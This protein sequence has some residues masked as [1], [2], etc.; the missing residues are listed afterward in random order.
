MSRHYLSVAVWQ[1]CLDLVSQQGTIQL[2]GKEEPA[3]ILARFIY[4]YQKRD[5]AVEIN[6]V[7]FLQ[8]SKRLLRG[9]RGDV[10]IQLCHI[11]SLIELSREPPTFCRSGNIQFH[12]I[13]LRLQQ[14]SSSEAKVTLRLLLV[15]VPLI[16]LQF[17]K[18]F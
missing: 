1:A 10:G 18:C 16:V 6:Q 8:G 14:L 5:L 9:C 4:Y 13:F 12:F 17:H 2:A 3:Q 7:S 11:F 15:F